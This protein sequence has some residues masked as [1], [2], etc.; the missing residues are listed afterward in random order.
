MPVFKK[1][2]AGNVPVSRSKLVDENR[3]INQDASGS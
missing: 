3:K 2:E 1:A